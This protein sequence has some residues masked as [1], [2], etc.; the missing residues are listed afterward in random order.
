MSHRNLLLLLVAALVCYA[1]Y[2]RAEQNPYA[3]YIAAGFSVIDRWALE[4][5]PDQ[6]LFDRAMDAMVDVLHEHG[7]EHSE[8]IDATSSDAF[9]EDIT[10]E[11]GGVGIRLQVFGDPPL[12]TVI[13]LPEP[14]SPAAEAD[15]R[16]G[17]R[18][19]AV[20][21][22]S[23][24]GLD[25]E[26][27]TTLVRG[28]VGDP[29]TLS[30]RRPG[31]SELRGVT[32]ERAVITVES[33]LGDLR[34]DDGR[35]MFR[36]PQDP[37]I[38]YLRITKFGDKTADEL[39]RILGEEHKTP[40]AGLI[41]DVR[42]D[43]GGAL[44]AAV[45]IC[46]LFLRAGRPIVTTRQR[47]RTIRERYVS[48]GTGAYPDLP[49]VML[50]DR[51]SA[52]ASEIVAA[53]LQDY[54]RAA[55]VGERTFGKGTV[56]QLIR[57]ESGR[58]LLKLT[59]ATYWRPS[60]KNIHRM[61]GDSEAGEWGVTPDPSLEAK[62]SKGQYK[63][64]RRYRLT[65]DLVGDDLDAELAQELAK[66]DGAPPADYVDRALQLGVEHLQEFLAK[67]PPKS[68]PSRPSSKPLSKGD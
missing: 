8:F 49:I 23:T 41:L 25:V 16:I 10:Q 64:W 32:L 68:P 38:A 21:G 53:C 36:L 43:G 5:V 52:S 4:E 48:T 47:D 24:E 40:L 19:E 66:V 18:L 56:Q 26:E 7:D 30:I 50:V 35:W 61:P 65:R 29:V 54:E 20:D 9:R 14:G 55:I 15:I 11:F 46:D 45:K 63:D 39:E 62:L 51:N 44:D 17:D 6:V 60:G 13:G 22:K 67:N 31:S 37:R 12:P 27:V 57:V 59:T 58:S 2:I 34:D 33:I 1:C 42:D 3:R 28:P